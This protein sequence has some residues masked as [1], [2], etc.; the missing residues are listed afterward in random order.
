MKADEDS[1]F[2]PKAPL[3]LPPVT[4]GEKQNIQFFPPQVQYSK[5]STLNNAINNDSVNQLQ[6]LQLQLL[7][8]L[9]Q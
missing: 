5:H 4:G 8:R 9:N 3:E 1:S 2:K 7:K 6:N